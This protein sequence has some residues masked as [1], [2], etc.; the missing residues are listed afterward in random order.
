MY[1]Y[2]YISDINECT[3]GDAA[4]HSTLATCTNIN[5]GYTCACNSGYQGNGIT[6][7][8]NQPNK[9]KQQYIY[10]II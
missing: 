1:I 2:A 9:Q 8:G 6:C 10:N 3:N 7:T 4:C 5:G